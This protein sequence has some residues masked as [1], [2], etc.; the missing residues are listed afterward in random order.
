MSERTEVNKCK[1]AK[2]ISQSWEWENG[3]ERGCDVVK[4]HKVGRKL[5]IE[6]HILKV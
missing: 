5:R 3:G 2:S 1:V 4:V 6:E